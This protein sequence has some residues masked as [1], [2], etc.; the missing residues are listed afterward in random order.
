MYGRI[1]FSGRKRTPVLGGGDE[2]KGRL[3]GREFRKV[4]LRNEDGGNEKSHHVLRGM[5]LKRR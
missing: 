2:R 4:F 5:G 3:T 1:Y